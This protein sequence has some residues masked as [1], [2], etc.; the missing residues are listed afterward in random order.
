MVNI[1][2][3]KWGSFLT[4][5]I[6]VFLMEMLDNSQ[7]ILIYFSTKYGHQWVS[8][9][10]AFSAFLITGVI[11]AS[12]SAIRKLSDY[13]TDGIELFFALLIFTIGVITL[14]HSEIILNACGKL[15]DFVRRKFS[16]PF[17]YSM[18]DKERD[19]TP[20]E[21]I[22]LTDVHED[23]S[24]EQKQEE[25][26]GEGGEAKKEG[27]AANEEDE[28]AEEIKELPDKKKRIGRIKLYVLVLV[29]V[30]FLE[31]PDKTMLMVAT[32]A[33]TSDYPLSIFV[34][35]AGALFTQSVIALII[36]KGLG[37]V[38]EKY[39]EY[40]EILAGVILSLT[41]AIKIAL[42]VFVGDISIDDL[43]GSGNKGRSFS[44]SSSSSSSSFAEF[45][46]SSSSSNY[47]FF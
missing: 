7:L 10:G 24:T 3:W 18:G 6:S 17:L 19:E 35:Y 34:G 5:Y 12:F 40:V 37:N 44:S 25:G 47:T 23:A 27:D 33:Q 39:G 43:F 38:A 26:E 16:D 42:M 36:G 29:T 28:V 21:E 8:A 11:G 14:S 9:L 4:T 13:V 31:L 22:S 30:F 32:L 20:E 1:F 45:M 15:S 2:E 41:G 46:S